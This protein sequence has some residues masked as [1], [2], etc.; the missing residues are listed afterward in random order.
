MDTT[1]EFVFGGFLFGVFT[2]YWA[3]TTH[4]NPWLWLFFGWFLPP[5]AGVLLLL[6][7]SARPA[8]RNLDARGRDDLI[9]VRKD[10]P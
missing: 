7:N 3:Q 8:P 5:V 6:K 10:I 4:R 9:A 2:A 1:T